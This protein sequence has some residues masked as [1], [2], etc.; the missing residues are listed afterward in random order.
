MATNDYRKRVI[1]LGEN[2]QNVFC[3]GSLGVEN[4]KRIDFKTGHIS[5]KEYGISFSSKNILVSFHPVTLE[6]NSEKKFI[7]ELIDALKQFKNCKIIFTSPNADHG[8]YIIIDKIKKFVKKKKNAI[9][10]NSFG[11]EDYLSCL[12]IVDVIIGNSSSGIIEA[13]SLKTFSVD[14]G[15]RQKGRVKAKSVLGCKINKNLIVKNIRVILSKNN[16]NINKHIF[17][18]PYDKNNTSKKLFLF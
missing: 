17:Q 4:I 15:D 6:P 14:L 1:Q 8:N 9:Y 13:P 3:V 7:K 16:N 10:V 12:K 5:K 2:P 18:N 11:H